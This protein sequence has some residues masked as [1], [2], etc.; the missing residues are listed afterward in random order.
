MTK[1]GR[2]LCAAKTGGPESVK[3]EAEGKGAASSAAD[4]LAVKPTSFKSLVGKGHP[5]FS[6]GRQQVHF[7]LDLLPF[8]ADVCTLLDADILGQVIHSVHQS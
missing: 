1:V 3:A 8:I 5:E 7:F 6:T 4:T 2:A